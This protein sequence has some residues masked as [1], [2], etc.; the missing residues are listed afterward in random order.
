MKGAKLQR[1]LD[2]ERST[3]AS[4]CRVRGA[5]SNVLCVGH[6]TL[7]CTRQNCTRPV[8]ILVHRHHQSARPAFKGYGYMDNRQLCYR[9]RA[10]ARTRS[11]EAAVCGQVGKWLLV[12]AWAARV[13]PKGCST[14][15]SKQLMLRRASQQ[16][17]SY[18]LCC[19]SRREQKQD[20]CFA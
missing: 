8:D 20:A 4:E 6:G 15:T 5:A 17:L 19:A 2:R 9:A 14:C 12:H 13:V 1:P 3:G 18:A 11:A 16:R 10:R 7:G